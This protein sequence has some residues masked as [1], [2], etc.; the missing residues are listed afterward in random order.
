MKTKRRSAAPGDRN[1]CMT[2]SRFEIYRCPDADP[3]TKRLTAFDRFRAKERPNGMRTFGQCQSTFGYRRR[4]ENSFAPSAT[5]DTAPE[6][7]HD[8]ESALEPMALAGGE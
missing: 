4:L 8:L 2:R 7:A 1:P 5:T 6:R 3:P